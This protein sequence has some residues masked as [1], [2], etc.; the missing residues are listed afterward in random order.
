MV[1]LTYPLPFVEAANFTPAARKV[2]DLVVIH[3]MENQ[4]KPGTARAVAEWFADPSRSP[5]ASAHYLCDEREVIQCVRDADVAWGAPG[6]NRTGLH[7]EHAGQ[8]SQSANEWGDE[9]S[10][11]MLHLSVQL[12]ATLCRAWAIPAV[13]LPAEPLAYKGSRGLTTHAEVSKAFR[14]SSH[15]DPGPNWPMAWY[16]G[17]VSSLL[18]EGSA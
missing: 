14:L 7:I 18:R 6:A 9:Y 8:A 2:I 15:T 17:R 11:S 3:S 5:R 13:F 16:V 10:M 4:E 1:G 12:C